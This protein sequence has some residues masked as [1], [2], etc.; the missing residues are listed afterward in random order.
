MLAILSSIFKY[1]RFSK[2]GFIST[3][4]KCFLKPGCFITPIMAQRTPVIWCPRKPPAWSPI[5]LSRYFDFE[6]AGIYHLRNTVHVDCFK[7]LLGS[8]LKCHLTMQKSPAL[9][10]GSSTKTC[11]S[12]IFTQMTV[13]RGHVLCSTSLGV[14]PTYFSL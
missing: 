14:F 11:I 2:C 4:L 1:I 8:R 13:L 10:P 5:H 9:P 7:L 12:Y 6:R 3:L